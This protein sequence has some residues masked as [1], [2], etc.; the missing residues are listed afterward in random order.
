MIWFFNEKEKNQWEV[1]E[2]KT[3]VPGYQPA[4]LGV[5]IFVILV[6]CDYR[7]T[8]EI[9]RIINRIARGVNEFLLIN[10]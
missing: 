9:T 8:I 6:T 2:N 3:G 5:D 4:P 7:L 1:G 10:I